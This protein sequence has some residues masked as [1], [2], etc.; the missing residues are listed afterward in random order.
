MSNLEQHQRAI[1]DLSLKQK[2]VIIGW[3][4]WNWRRFRKYHK[5][6]IGQWYGDKAYMIAKIE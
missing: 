6:V 3:L 1:K 2:L 4:F 5:C